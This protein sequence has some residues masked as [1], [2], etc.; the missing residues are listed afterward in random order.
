MP[1]LLHLQASPMGER[2]IST[3]V[4][5]V[6]ID[7]YRARHPDGVVVVRD[8]FHAPLPAFDEVGVG[9]QQSILFGCEM[10]ATQRETWDEVEAVIEE[11]RAADAIVVSVPMWNFSIPYPLKHWLDVVLQPSYAFSWSPETG[12]TGLLGS[13]EK[14]VQ[15]VMSRAGAYES[16]AKHAMDHQTPYLRFIFE[17]MGYSDVRLLAVE[18]TM[19]A[20]PDAACA[21]FERAMQEAHEAGRLL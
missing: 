12:Y 14:P 8:L 18:P 11:L 19:L 13:A 15:I 9:G 16:A 7:E 20:G 1:T 4:A 5:N 21:A 2:S 6:V 10:N 17:F 3:R